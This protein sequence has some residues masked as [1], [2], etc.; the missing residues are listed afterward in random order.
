MIV[1]IGILNIFYKAAS[2]DD[3]LAF[4][5]ESLL[6]PSLIAWVSYAAS[7]A[8]ASVLFFI[9][10][11]KSVFVVIYVTLV[12]NVLTF[13]V[14]VEIVALCCVIVAFVATS[15]AIVADNYDF[16]ISVSVYRV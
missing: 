11:D 6:F 4:Y 9:S 1:P 8:S 10:V 2:I 5:T 14:M 12:S 16:C 13:V 7:C 3:N 15:Y